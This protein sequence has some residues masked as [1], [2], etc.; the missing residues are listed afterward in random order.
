MQACTPSTNGERCARCRRRVAA[1]CSCTFL[2]RLPPSAAPPSPIRKVFDHQ[3]HYRF[4]INS[5]TTAQGMREDL[6]SGGGGGLPG[7]HGLSSGASA[8]LALPL[9][10]GSTPS[11]SGALAHAAQRRRMP[12]AA[13]SRRALAGAAGARRAING[14]AGRRG[15]MRRVLSAGD[16]AR[17]LSGLGPGG[18]AGM[19]H[20]LSGASEDG[21]DFDDSRMSSTVTSPVQ[22]GAAGWPGAATDTHVHPSLLRL[23]GPPA[24]TGGAPGAARPPRHPPAPGDAADGA[25]PGAPACGPLQPAAAGG[26]SDDRSGMPKAHGSF[27]DVSTALRSMAHGIGPSRLSGGGTGAAGGGGPMAGQTAYGDGPTGL[28]PFD[29]PQGSPRGWWPPMGHSEAAGRRALGRR[30]GGGPSDTLAARGGGDSYDGYHRR[31]C[32]A[33]WHLP[34]ERAESR[35]KAD[36]LVCQPCF[37]AKPWRAHSCGLLVPQPTPP[38]GAPRCPPPFNAAAGRWRWTPRATCTPASRRWRRPPSAPRSRSARSSSWCCPTPAQR[39]GW[40]AGVSGFGVQRWGGG[41][42]RSAR[43]AAGGCSTS[44]ASTVNESLCSTRGRCFGDGRPDAALLEQPCSTHASSSGPRAPQFKPLP[45]SRFFATHPRSPSTALRSR[46][47][48]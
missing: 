41:A 44:H 32:A 4:L 28:S 30:T 15:A 45:L 3:H 14:V 31:G 16:Q 18:A 6:V 27:A 5:A 8:G 10:T 1:S 43:G 24:C 11:P 40:W 29:T 21:S 22:P 34:R 25:P 39:R 20:E 35:G 48:C 19:R 46:C 37:H 33:G 17:P 23:E 2:S 36:G 9:T 12:P 13:G 42:L 26:P 7:P 38:S 47:W